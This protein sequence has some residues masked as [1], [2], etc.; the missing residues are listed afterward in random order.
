[1]IGVEENEKHWIESIKAGDERVF[2]TLY[3]VYYH[4]LFCIAPVGRTETGGGGFAYRLERLSRGSSFFLVPFFIKITS[5]MPDGLAKA[6]LFY[7]TGPTV[8][9]KE[10]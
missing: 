7:Q 10:M 4:R 1:M 8:S 9:W 6:N 3:A 5:S 2:Q